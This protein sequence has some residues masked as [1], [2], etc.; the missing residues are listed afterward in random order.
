MSVDGGGSDT[1][2]VNAQVVDVL[3]VDA[4]TDV[5]AVRARSAAVADAALLDAVVAVADRD[6]LGFDAD[7]VAVTLAWTRTTARY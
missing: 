3:A 2:T 1:Q 6:R 5:L 7:E 4:L